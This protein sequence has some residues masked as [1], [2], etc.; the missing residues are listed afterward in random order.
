MSY[1][2]KPARLRQLR[3]AAAPHAGPLTVAAGPITAA[4][5]DAGTARG[6]AAACTAWYLSAMG[7]VYARAVSGQGYAAEVLAIITANPRPPGTAWPA[8]SG[9]A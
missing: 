9:E 5:D 1:A 6:I 7:E 4:G 2:T 3:E 8:A